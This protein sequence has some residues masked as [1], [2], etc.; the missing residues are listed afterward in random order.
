VRGGAPVLDAATGLP[1][2]R[3]VIP[4][5][6][7]RNMLDD[8]I[9]LSGSYVI[10][11]AIPSPEAA[12]H[13]AVAATTPLAAAARTYA[14]KFQQY[15]PVLKPHDVLLP[16]VCESWGGLHTGVT[17]RLQA[18]ARH[19]SGWA[20]PSDLI[21]CRESLS[22][23]I[24]SIWRMRLSCALLLGRVGLVSSALD[25]LMG[26]PARSSTLAYRISHPYVRAQEFGRLR[27]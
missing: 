10:D 20:D 22:P 8:Q 17:E 21:D 13:L 27:G 24:L 2:L 12:R 7:A 9:G 1:A 4:D 15:S 25:K 18:W 26:V 16:V 11:T 23:Q 14:R 6:V 5:R 19:L 3:A